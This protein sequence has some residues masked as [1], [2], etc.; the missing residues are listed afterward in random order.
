MS[1]FTPRF[2]K[3]IPFVKQAETVY[4]RGH[5]GDDK[6]VVVERDPNDSGGTTKWGLDAA[7]HGEG[8][9]KLTWPQAEQIY[10]DWYWLGNADGG[11]FGSCDLLPDKY[12]EVV[13]DT[14]INCGFGAARR[15]DAAA[16]GDP[17]KFLDL[18]DERYRDIV[19]EHPKNR[20]FLQG[21]LNR[22]QDLR[23]RLNIR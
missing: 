18:R 3:F 13:F 2:E 11:H 17:A 14:R 4:K 8:V 6:F 22:S 15:L 20:R 7:T 12:G 10:F 5:Y 21:W 9:A 23:T 19:E 1:K 16:K